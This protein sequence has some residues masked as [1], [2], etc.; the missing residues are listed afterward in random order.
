ML[1]VLAESESRQVRRMLIDRLLQMPDAVRPLLPKRLGDERWYVVRNVLCIA[2]DLPGGVPGLDAA[3]FCQHADARVRREALRVLF[4]HPRE[5]TR[6]LCR[7]LAD[8]DERVKRLAVSALAE[9]GV[10]E[11]AVPL[12]VNI[13]TEGEADEELR[14]VAVRALTGSRSALA[15]EALLKVS[16]IK[17]RSIMDRISERT[18]SPILIA[19][20][21][22]L[23]AFVADAR[24]RTRLDAAARSRDPTVAK[25]AADALRGG[26]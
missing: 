4:Q 26:T 18:A 17:R 11:P 6:A 1:E 16:E 2:A 24:A 23:G 15:L 10:P 5:R 14:V 25:A 3:P 21:Q 22:A 12:L 13:A 7:A 9:G 8:E 20:V 19:A